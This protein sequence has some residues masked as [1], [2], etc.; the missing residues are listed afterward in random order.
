[1]TESVLP[2]QVA[3]L[4]Q[5]VCHN[6]HKLHTPCGRQNCITRKRWVTLVTANVELVLWPKD[7]LDREMFLGL[8]PVRAFF[9][10]RGMTP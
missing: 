10:F 6:D 3:H 2:Y 4:R 5:T 1:M 9:D 7:I 8:T